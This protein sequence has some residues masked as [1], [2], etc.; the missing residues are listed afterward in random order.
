MMG[1]PGDLNLEL[2][3]GFD[4]AIVDFPGIY[5]MGFHCNL[6]GKMLDSLKF[7][8]FNWDCY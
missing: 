3:L 4:W 8:G 5:I 7:S 2:L 6:P 1:I